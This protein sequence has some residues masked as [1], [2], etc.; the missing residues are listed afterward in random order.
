MYCISQVIDNTMT[1]KK[2]R[3]MFYNVENFFDYY[4]DSTSN[5]NEFTPEGERRWTATKY[6]RKRNSIYKVIKAVGGWVPVTLIG[7]CEIENELV[8]NNLIDNTPLNKYGYNYV[9][10]DSPDKRGIDVC[11]I[12]HE[13][14]F[15]VIYSK[16][17]NIKDTA[18]LDFTTRDI[19]YVVGKIDNDTIHVFVNHWTSRYR[20]LFESEKY[21]LLASN[22]LLEITDSICN[23]APSSNIIIMGD[24]NDNPYNESI[25]R[26]T[27][28]SDC[29]IVNLNMISKNKNVEGTMKYKQSWHYF[30]QILVS[31]SLFDS[32]KIESSPSATIFDA[33][34]LLM[35]DDIHLG[36]KLNRTYYGY[37]YMGGFSDH[38]P[39]Y[40]DLVVK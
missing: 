30:D 22:K 10:F 34:F 7:L 8:I 38:L 19:L 24:F 21:R 2:F 9:H 4:I 11:L 27:D 17:L 1:E 35:P 12:Y 40:F 37:K 36:Y 28:L 15:S 23:S 31:Q 18:D 3:V 13:A 16:A 25:T 5:Y 14:N 29:D 39:I 32:V 6:I 26:I 20:G 33:G